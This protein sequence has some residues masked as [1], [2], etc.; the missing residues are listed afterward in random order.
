MTEFSTMDLPKHLHTRMEAMGFNTPTPIQARAI[1][2]ALNGQDV[3]GLAQTGTGKTAAFGVPL[4][5]QM[6]EY[7]QK[8]AAGTVRGLILA[9]TRELANQIAETLRGLTEGSPLKTGLVVGG[10]SINPQINRLSRGT[11]ILV[12]T[13]GRL[14]DL[15]DRGAI[16]LG[17]VR[18]LVLEAL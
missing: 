18:H 4:V 8:P 7:G 16:D 14:I 3:L 10:V 5:A 12:A 9:P 6:L 2:H 13:P 11:D 1:P 17:T 15:M